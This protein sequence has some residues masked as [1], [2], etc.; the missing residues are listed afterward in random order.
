MEEGG[1][2]DEDDGTMNASALTNAAIGMAAR[3]EAA[4]TLISWLVLQFPLALIVEMIQLLV[5]DMVM[6]DG[7]RASS[8]A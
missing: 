3:R 1:T 2:S 4:L 8:D 7:R 6:V 5:W